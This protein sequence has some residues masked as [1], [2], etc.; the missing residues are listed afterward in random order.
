MER[1]IQNRRRTK[2]ERKKD[3]EE[4]SKLK[5]DSNRFK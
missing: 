4:L 3:I 2:K 1:K 5:I